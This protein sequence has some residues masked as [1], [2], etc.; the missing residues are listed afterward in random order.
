MST[1]ISESLPPS[2]GARVACEDRDAKA[3]DNQQSLSVS[4][5]KL[6]GHGGGI[7]LPENI[8]ELIEAYLNQ[9]AKREIA[10]GIKYPHLI[11]SVSVIGGRLDMSRISCPVEGSIVSGSTLTEAVDKHIA[12]FKSFDPLKDKQDQI[13]RLQQECAQIEA[14]RS[15]A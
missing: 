7:I 5:S 3:S 8:E 11:V 12:D 14:E 15:V 1:V 13:A 6:D 10:A 4:A 2:V 9:Q